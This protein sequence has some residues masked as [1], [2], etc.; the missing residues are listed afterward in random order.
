MI[1]VIDVETTGLNPYRHDRIVELAAVVIDQDGKVIREL[2]TLVNP[3]R[4][5]GPSH[6]H[7]LTAKDVHEAPRFTDIASTLT[8]FLDG[9]VAVAGHNVRFDLSFLTAEFDRIGRAFPDCPSLCTMQLAGGGNLARACSDYGVPFDGQAHAAL[10]DARA[11]A[12]LLAVLLRD[13]P[14]LSASVLA[15]PPIRWSPIPHAPVRLLTR[16]EAER[17]HLQPPSYI[18]KL[19]A[20][21][22]PDLPADVQDAA[23]LAYTALLDRALA[24]RHVDEDEGKSLLEIA[25]KWSMSGQ[26]VQRIHREYV[27]RLGMAALTDGTVSD[28]ERRDLLHVGRMLGLSATDLDSV[29]AEGSRRLAMGQVAAAAPVQAERPGGLT[30]KCVCFTG[31][32]QCRVNGRSLTRDMAMALAARH[33]MVVTE[34][35]TKKLDVLVVADPLTQSGKAKKARQYGIPIMHELVFWRALGLNVE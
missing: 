4:D 24:D 8:E 19:L 17:R 34:S 13:A 30:G 3:E 14:H 7:G 21:L 25:T 11:A 1:A 10:D 35:V 23:A 5:M 27:V 29:L 9:C 18:E 31:E 16:H 22:Q 20:R 28:T 33:G 12:Q 32:C 2:A 6:I 26:L 15:L